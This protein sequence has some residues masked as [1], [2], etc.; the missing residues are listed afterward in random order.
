MLGILNSL[1]G[2]GRQF[3]IIENI[4]LLMARSSGLRGPAQS[5]KRRRRSAK[6]PVVLVDMTNNYNDDI[7]TSFGNDGRFVTYVLDL[8][9]TLLMLY[10]SFFVIRSQKE[11]YV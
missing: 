5:T 7:R 10:Y 1:H 11:T 9:H 6:V 3:F 8:Y 2:K 4:C